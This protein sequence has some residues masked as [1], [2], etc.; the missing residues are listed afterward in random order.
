MD[1]SNKCCLLAIALTIAF[2]C[3][4]SGVIA[5]LVLGLKATVKKNTNSIEENN[6]I[7]N[8]QL[9]TSNLIKEWNAS[10]SWN[11]V[12]DTLGKI[13]M[14]DVNSTLKVRFPNN[15]YIPSAPIKGG[16]QFYCQPIIFPTKAVV[17]RYK[18]MFPKNFD[19]VKGGKLPGLWFGDIGANG[20]NH[21]DAGSSFRLMWRADGEA[22]AYVYLPKTQLNSYYSM[23]GY[24][25]NDVFGDSVWRGVFKFETGVWNEVELYAKVNNEM[26]Y[27]DHIGLTINNVTMLYTQLMWSN[28]T[29]LI[30]GLMMHTFFGGNDKTWATPK[31]QE[32]SFKDIEVSTSDA[33]LKVPDSTSPPPAKTSLNRKFGIKL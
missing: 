24:H 11:I 28:S 1:V 12:D 8:V 16:M 23:P 29:T 22:E 27:S 18:V 26:D 20:G 21:I 19:W 4:A 25:G 17:F 32:I 5:G 2:A 10:K 7:S 3:V 15:S 9:S 6:T 14:Q 33:M 13:N 30:N 31:D